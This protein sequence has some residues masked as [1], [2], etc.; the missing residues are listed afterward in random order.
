MSRRGVY[1]RWGGGRRER[2][3]ESGCR[4]GNRISVLLNYS[5]PLS[6]STRS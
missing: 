3:K 4:E 5:S 2:E 6:R 1:R